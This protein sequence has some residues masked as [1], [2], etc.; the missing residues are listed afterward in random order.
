VARGSV[1]DFDPDLATGVGKFWKN[2]RNVPTATGCEDPQ[3]GSTFPV[4]NAQT[5]FI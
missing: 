2:V 4:Y 5:I 3:I 1:A